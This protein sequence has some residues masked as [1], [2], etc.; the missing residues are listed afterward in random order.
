LE[1]RFD[2][3]DA[4]EDEADFR[5]ARATSA[6]LFLRAGA[7]DDALYEAPHARRDIP[8]AVSE[9]VAELT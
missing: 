8:E 6:A 2:E 4:S 9:A 5:R 1:R 7:Y 3:L